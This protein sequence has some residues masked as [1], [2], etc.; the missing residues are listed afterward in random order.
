MGYL[1][2]TMLLSAISNTAG[3][4]TAGKMN[5]TPGTFCC[6]SLLLLLSLGV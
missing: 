2:L 3:N 1:D 6:L 5:V 4:Q